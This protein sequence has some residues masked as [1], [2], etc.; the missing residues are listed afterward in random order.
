MPKVVTILTET[1][2]GSEAF[3]QY[4]RNQGIHFNREFMAATT[5]AS[6]NVGLRHHFAIDEVVA[7]QWAV[8]NNVELRLFQTTTRVEDFAQG[9]SHKDCYFTPGAN[10]SILGIEPDSPIVWHPTE[11]CSP[12][13]EVALATVS[14]IQLPGDAIMRVFNMQSLSLVQNYMPTVPGPSGTLHTGWWNLGPDPDVPNG[15]FMAFDNLIQPSIE[16][17]DETIPLDHDWLVAQH[18]TMAL[19]WGVYDAYAHPDRTQARVKR[20]DQE[21]CIEH[22]IVLASDQVEPWLLKDYEQPV[23]RP[24]TARDDPMYG[25]C[26]CTGHA[27]GTAMNMAKVKPNQPAKRAAAATRALSP[28]PHRRGQLPPSQTLLTISSTKR[29]Q[30]GPLLKPERPR[31]A[32]Q[33]HMGSQR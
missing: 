19:T 5:V 8:I 24:R 6:S 7:A 26:P 23:A 25:A 3:C 16:R 27:H 9:T 20:W 21:C 14:G 12:I 1:R 29:C 32:A 33:R 22:P 11:G 10:V 4:F 2:K 30:R 28:K 18:K 31:Q 17:P 13:R 15:F